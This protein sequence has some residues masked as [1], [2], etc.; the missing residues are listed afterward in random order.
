VNELVLSYQ[1]LG[2]KCEVLVEQERK[3]E[4]VRIQQLSVFSEDVPVR[5]L[6]RN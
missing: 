1:E 4:Q 6:P 3:L 5:R 2:E